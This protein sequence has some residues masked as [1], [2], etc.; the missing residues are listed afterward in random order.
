MRVR[1][2]HPTLRNINIYHLLSKRVHNDQ[3]NTEATTSTVC[4]V[5]AKGAAKLF[6]KNMHSV[7]DAPSSEYRRRCVYGSASADQRGIST[8]FGLAKNAIN[9]EDDEIDLCN[10][11][12]DS[13]SQGQSKWRIYKKPK[14]RKPTA[15]DCDLVKQN[16]QANLT[17]GR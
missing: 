5:L 14:I 9:N 2:S 15:V 6:P 13:Q 11:I 3:T 4:R 16:D 12:V 17:N 1:L 7:R 8:T 10:E